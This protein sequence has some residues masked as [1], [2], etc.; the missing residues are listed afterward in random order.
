MLNLGQE[1]FGKTAVL[2]I[3]IIIYLNLC[4]CLLSLNPG[5][6]NLHLYLN[7]HKYLYNCIL[8]CIFSCSYWGRAKFN[9]FVCILA[10]CMF[11]CLYKF[12]IIQYILKY[13]VDFS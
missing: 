4:N 9:K 1:I 11:I 7:L 3:L 13:D 8:F 12:E 2:V 10:L 6:N 5:G